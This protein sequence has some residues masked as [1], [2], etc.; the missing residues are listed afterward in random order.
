METRFVAYDRLGARRGVLP[1]VLQ[2]DYVP[3]KN[4][5]PTLTMT[6]PRRARHSKYL[7]ND[8]EV[9]F[10]FRH[11]GKWVEPLDARFRL[12]S[13]DFDYLEEAETKV[14]TFIGIGEAVRGIYIFDDLGLPVTEDGA[15]QF[16][17]A[18]AGEILCKV[19]DAAKD[20]GWQ[21]FDRSFT[22]THDSNGLRWNDEINVSLDVDNSFEAVLMYFVRGGLLDFHW[23]GRTLHAYNN[24]TYSRDSTSTAAP[25]RFNLSGGPTSVDSAPELTDRESMATHVIV[26]GEEGLRWEFPT[27]AVLPEGRREVFLSYSGV[28]EEATARILAAPTIVKYSNALK[29]TTRQYRINHLTKIK[30]LIDYRI[31][32][33]AMVEKADGE[34][35]RMQ[36]YTVAVTVNENGVQGYVGL[37]DKIDTLLEI[38]NE[39]VQRISGGA[40]TESPGEVTPSNRKPSAPTKVMGTTQT[41][42]DV[43]GVPKSSVMVSFVHDGKDEKGLTVELDRFSVQYRRGDSGPW[44]ELFVLE[45]TLRSGSYPALDT[46]GNDGEVQ[47]YQFRVLAYARN[48]TLSDPSTIIDVWTKQDTTVPEVP[49]KPI[50]FAHG[51]T[52]TI[53]TDHRT[54][55]NLVR[56]E[57]DYSH[58]VVEMATA[59]NASTWHDAGIILK[60]HKTLTLAGQG[61]GNRWFRLVAVDTSGNRSQPSTTAVAQTKPLVETDYLLRELDGAKITDNSIVTRSLK[62]TE[63]M[64]AKLLTV[65]EIKAGDIDVNNLT[66]DYGFIQSFKANVLTANIIT[67]SMIKGDAIDGK[68]ITGARI[69]SAASGERVEMTN[70]GIRALDADGK[71]LI[72]IGYGLKNGLSVRD[73]YTNQM[74][75]LQN[76]VFGTEIINGQ[77]T[78]SAYYYDPN[79]D[80]LTEAQQLAASRL[81]TNNHRVWSDQRVFPTGTLE[82][83]LPVYHES[84]RRPDGRGYANATFQAKS[85]SHVFMIWFTLTANVDTAYS[86][87]DHEPGTSVRMRFG[88]KLAGSSDAVRWG[89][90]RFITFVNYSYYGVAQSSFTTHISLEEGQIY[91]IHYLIEMMDDNSQGAYAYA[92][93]FTIYSIPETMGYINGG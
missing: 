31:G 12:Q 75:S 54:W 74:T 69:R 60:D 51:A 66:A 52:F 34:W 78:N 21:G 7:E 93:D 38:L 9:A 37:G 32:D 63:D 43:W 62:V 71:E 15:V 83:S 33:Y 22:S 49:S 76:H 10:Q 81:E 30:P 13:T 3:T 67:G 8:P 55:N 20:R 14:Y 17:K 85:F 47:L 44:T 68:T 88:T 92:D 45:S 1:S 58:A 80:N 24:G 46:L 26:N 5:L 50:A 65:Y 36:I 19:W 2:A 57:N 84:Q 77:N 39:K 56:T 18:T 70:E 25:L 23:E 89:S 27:G 11:E 87:S 91:E 59:A 64:M 41:Y 82:K 61:Y 4:E 29:N 53:E 73:P 40:S 42:I 6:Y 28:D 86:F 72:R 79:Y 90:A 35:E 48:G 16:G